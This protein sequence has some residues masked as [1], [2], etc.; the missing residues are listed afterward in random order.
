MRSEAGFG[1]SSRSTPTTTHTTSSHSQTVPAPGR[2]MTGSSPSRSSSGTRPVMT[3][4]RWRAW[5][6]GNGDGVES[7]AK[8]LGDVDPLELGLRPQAEAVDERRV[9]ERLDV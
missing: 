5:S 8:D 3:I 4:V 7:R 1:A 9:R 6:A 2:A